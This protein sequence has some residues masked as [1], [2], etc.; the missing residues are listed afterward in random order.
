MPSASTTSANTKMNQFS[1]L[2]RALL[3]GRSPKTK[4]FGG[5]TSFLALPPEIRS[6]I[7][8]FIADDAFLLDVPHASYLGLL[9][10]CKKIRAEMAF[11][12]L[13]PSPTA[14]LRLREARFADT[15]NLPPQ[16]PYAEFCSLSNLQISVPHGAFSNPFRE[17]ANILTL[18][19]VLKLHLSCLTIISKQLSEAPTYNELVLFVT[20]IGCLLAPG[21]CLQNHHR[22]PEHCLR[23]FA[24][25]PE[26]FA[27]LQNSVCNVRMV[28][29]HVQEMAPEA[30][31]DHGL[32]LLGMVDSPLREAGKLKKH[33][34]EMW[35]EVVSEG[36]ITR[37]IR[38][39]WKRMEPRARGGYKRVDGRLLKGLAK[40]KSSRR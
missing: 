40:H 38:F 29:L 31:T 12:S 10:S 23:S 20:H 26:E 8:H 13:R 21:L 37:E 28:K 11:E 22:K 7:Y 35:E 16:N 24:T 5:Q 2:F 39:V 32:R 6:I 14:K 19:P 3:P 36:G 30:A 33:G 1:A 15:I 4:R 27:I 18:P 25:R 17:L 34:W 9:Y